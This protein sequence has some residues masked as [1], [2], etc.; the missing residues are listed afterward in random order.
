MGEHRLDLVFARNIGPHRDGAHA[1]VAEFG[2]G[3][4]GGGLPKGVVERDVGAGLRQGTCYCAS[5]SLYGLRSER[6]A[7]QFL[8]VARSR[9]RLSIMPW[10]MQL[11][12]GIRDQL[13]SLH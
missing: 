10:E 11:I 3:R 8:D 12:S 4:L 6:K 1:E 9:L 13:R 2:R 7:R 5:D